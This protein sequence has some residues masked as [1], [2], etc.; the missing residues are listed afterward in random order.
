MPYRERENSN[1]YWELAKGITIL[2]KDRWVILSNRI[3][4]TGFM[5][6]SYILLWMINEKLLGI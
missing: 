1:F 3:Y 5:E 6:S 2:L 4:L